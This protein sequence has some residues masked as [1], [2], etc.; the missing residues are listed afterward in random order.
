MSKLEQLINELCPDG[1]EFVKLE[2]VIL[3]LKTGLNPRKNFILNT[4]NAQNYYV[5]VREIIDGKIVFLDKTDR[6]DDDALLL[7]NNRSNLEMGDV[8]FSGT[9]TVG[10]VAVVE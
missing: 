7:I 1:V 6:V 4:E 5:T 10:R 2:E 8:L 3:S 9:G